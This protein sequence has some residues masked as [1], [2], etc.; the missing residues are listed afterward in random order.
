MMI[1][2]LKKL[3]ILIIFIAVVWFSISNK[4]DIL[5]G[6]LLFNNKLELPVFLFTIIVLF[7]GIFLGM[8]FVKIAN[9]INSK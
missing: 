5:I 3:L 9:M 2:I 7:I 8:I 1:G 4:G 6:L